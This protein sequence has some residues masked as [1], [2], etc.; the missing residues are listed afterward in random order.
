MPPK[1]KYNK[2]SKEEDAKKFMGKC[3]KDGGG[4]YH[5]LLVITL[6]II[7]KCADHLKLNTFVVIF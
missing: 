1:R 4:G 3:F 5:L 2:Q 7:K 6:V